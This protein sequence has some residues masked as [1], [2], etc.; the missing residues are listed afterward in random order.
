MRKAASFLLMCVLWSGLLAAQE[1]PLGGWQTHFSYLSAQHIEQVQSRFF[2]ATYN[3]LFSYDPAQDSTIA[4]SKINGLHDTGISD[5]AYDPA[6]QLLLLAY[7]NG[8][9]DLMYL[10]EQA[11]PRQ[12]IEWPLLR[13]ATGLPTDRRSYGLVFRNGLA[14]LAT[15][16]GIVVLDPK[17]REV[18]ETYR[19]IGREGAEVIV[20]DLTFATNSLYALTSQGILRTSMEA[21]VNR[22]F[23]GNWQQVAAPF[24]ATSL[25][26]FQN[27]LYAGRAGEGIFRNTNN[28]WQVAYPSSSQRYSLTIARDRLIAALDNRVVVLS[29]QDQVTGFRDPLL[30]APQEATLDAANNLWVADARR[31]L[32]SN[33]QGTYRSYSPPTADTTI[34]SRSD[35]LIVD[36]NGVQWIRLPPGL[37]GGILVRNPTTQQQRFLTASPNN[38]GLPSSRINSLSLDRDGL[39]WFAADRGVGYF[40]PNGILSSGAVNAI[41]PVFGQRRLLSNEFSTAIV[42]EPGNRKWVGTR[43]GLYLFSSDGTQLIRQFTATNSPLPSNQI[44]ALRFDEPNGRLYADT[45]KGLVSYRSD[46]SSPASSLHTITVFPNPVRPGYAGVVGIRGLP[47]NAVVRITDL[48]GRLVYETRSQGGTASWNL[49]DYTGHRARGGVYLVL[50]TAQDGTESMAGKLAIVE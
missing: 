29:L 44:L 18:R 8:N 40:V 6:Q 39:V 1:I 27:T 41:L 20:S 24:E 50:L 38:G 42:T 32:V 15:A 23:Y 33:Y 22:Q 48:A 17:R 45:P 12:I 21:G 7:R 26:T 36:R 31:G 3:G 14:Y 37:G 11:L 2:C 25:E 47:D 19:Y 46:A 30:G 28:G 35:S 49:L 9:L 16:F 34:T 13:D 4:Y 43:N 5:M 10:D